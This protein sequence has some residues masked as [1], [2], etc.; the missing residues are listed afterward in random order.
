MDE[1]G[2]RKH[3]KLFEGSAIENEYLETISS[4]GSDD[5]PNIEFRVIFK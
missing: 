1:Q 5:N 4:Y 3:G 2:L